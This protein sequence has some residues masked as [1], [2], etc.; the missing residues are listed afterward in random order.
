MNEKNQNPF[1]HCLGGCGKIGANMFAFSNSKGKGFYLD[2]GIKFFDNDFLGV[3]YET[4]DFNQFNYTDLLISHGHEDHI[5]AMKFFLKEKT[6]TVYCSSYTKEL[7]LQRVENPPKFFL[8]EDLKSFTLRDFTITPFEVEHSIPHTFGFL[9]QYQDRNLD[10]VYC[11]DFKISKDEFFWPKK[12]KPFIR[13]NSKLL[14]MLDSTNAMKEGSSNHEDSILPRLEEELKSQKGRFFFT[15]F[16]SNTERLANIVKLCEKHQKSVIP[17]G[18]S[19]EK[20]IEVAKKFN[21][22]KSGTEFYSP[23]EPLALDQTVVLVTGNQGEVR[24]SLR[25]IAVGEDRYFKFGPEDTVFFSSFNIPGNGLTIQN[26]KNKITDSDAKIVDGGERAGIHV[27]GHASPES[28]RA[29][30]EFLKPD[31]IIPIHGETQFLKR[32]IEIAKEVTDSKTLFHRIDSGSTVQIKKDLSFHLTHN[33]DYK[34]LLFNDDGIPQE[35]AFISERKKLAKDGI[36]IVQRKK[37]EILID[38][39]GVSDPPIW[40]DDVLKIIKSGKVVRGEDQETQVK[41][42]VFAKVGQR[43]VVLIHTL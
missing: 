37:K 40:E 11:S 36:V 32:H 43:P 22:I 8:F 35:Q 18:R 41:R 34:L 38:S 30:Y 33:R 7:I 1:F 2:C 4:P 15:F 5:G 26:L 10:L 42:A 19:I 9:I 21:Y 6:A 13:E 23:D 14:L 12:I 31:T 16:S 27:S 28:L 17:Y 3:Q 24:S 20:N 25:R 29:I 39:Y